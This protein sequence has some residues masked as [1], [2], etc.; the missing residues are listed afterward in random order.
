MKVLS[1]EQIKL[2]LSLS[3]ESL[4]KS[5]ELIISKQ[6]IVA[7]FSELT[8]RRACE[9]HHVFECSNTVKVGSSS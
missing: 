1:D 5:G 9:R 6:I 4:A 3:V 7:A 2:A 8:E